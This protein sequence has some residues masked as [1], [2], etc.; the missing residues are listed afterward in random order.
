MPRPSARLPLVER[1]GLS[2]YKHAQPTR[3]RFLASTTLSPTQSCPQSFLTSNSDEL[4]MSFPWLSLFSMP[5][6]PINIV[7]F[8]HFQLREHPHPREPNPRSRER[9]LGS[10]LLLN[11]LTFQSSKKSKC[12]R[13]ILNYA[14]TFN[15][16]L[17]E[18]KTHNIAPVITSNINQQRR[19]IYS[20]NTLMF[21]RPRCFWIYICQAGQCAALFIKSPFKL[22]FSPHYLPLSSRQMDL[23]SKISFP[24]AFVRGLSIPVVFRYATVQFC[25][26]WRVPILQHCL[27]HCPR[28]LLSGLFVSYIEEIHRL[29]H[30]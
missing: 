6:E 18:S 12:L 20:R 23:Y 30:V 10:W 28:R 1:C 24:L 8:M 5:D 4:R 14:T 29:I 11:C 27:V 22:G 3:Y 17:Y 13:Q 16:S 9:T 26:F 21:K 15:V 2:I 7:I 19:L 25:W